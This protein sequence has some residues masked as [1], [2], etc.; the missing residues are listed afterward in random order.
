LPTEENLTIEKLVYGGDG[1]SRLE[2][3]VVFTPYVLPGEKVRGEVD[4]IKNDLWRGRLLEV[5]EPSSNRV[6]PQCLYFQRCGGC[7]YQHADYAFQVE[8]K[9]SILR[10]ALLSCGQDRI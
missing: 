2:S 7:H 6:T 1:L 5:L 8:Q 9:R 3:K 10:E 4:R